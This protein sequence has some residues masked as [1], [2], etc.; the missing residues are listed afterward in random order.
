[1]SFLGD[2]WSAVTGSGGKQKQNQ[3]TSGTSKSDYSQNTNQTQNQQQMQEM[4]MQQLA[5][6]LQQL[7][8]TGT[9]SQQNQWG[10][11]PQDP[12]AQFG[13]QGLAS[14]LRGGYQPGQAMGNLGSM[15]NALQEQYPQFQQAWNDPASS[16]SAQSQIQG[17][18]GVATDLYNNLMKIEDDF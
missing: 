3:S 17:M 13:Q 10:L 2:A 15:S 14:L 8:G 9:Q 1:M 16:Q 7:S 4:S 12:Y 18:T 5:S 6:A 11:A